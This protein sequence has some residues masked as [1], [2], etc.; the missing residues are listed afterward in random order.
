M[1]KNNLLLYRSYDVLAR[2]VPEAAFGAPGKAK[3]AVYTLPS[4]SHLVIARDMLAS[5]K[6]KA[7]RK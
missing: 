5:G 4:S 3:E 1:L 6:L 2:D 7:M